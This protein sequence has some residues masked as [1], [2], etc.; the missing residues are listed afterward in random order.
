MYIYI[1]MYIFR[2]NVHLYVSLCLALCTC[3]GGCFI[4]FHCKPLEVKFGSFTSYIY[5]HTLTGISRSEGFNDGA[6]PGLWMVSFSCKY[7]FI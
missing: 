2:Q 7:S 5:T 1:Y 6:G 3:P 4:P